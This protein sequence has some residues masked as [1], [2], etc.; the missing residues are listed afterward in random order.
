MGILK[1]VAP[2]PIPFS[3]LLGGV[4]HTALVPWHSAAQN[5]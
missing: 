5:I 1:N 2:A 3:Q 4:V